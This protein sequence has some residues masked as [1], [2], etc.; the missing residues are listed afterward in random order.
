MLDLQAR[1]GVQH[2]ALNIASV[3]LRRSDDVVVR[4]LNSV[5]TNRLVYHLEPLTSVP[6]DGEED[7]CE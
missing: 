6:G 2:Y 4:L 5:V 7:L 3:A 1:A